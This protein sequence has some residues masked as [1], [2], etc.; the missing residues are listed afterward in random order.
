[1]AE[2]S[3]SSGLK[4]IDASYNQHRDKNKNPF[5]SFKDG[6]KISSNPAVFFD[7]SGRCFMWELELEEIRP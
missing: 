3:D 6:E 7:R 4:G 2:I 1:M 5:L